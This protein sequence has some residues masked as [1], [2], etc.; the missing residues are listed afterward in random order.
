MSEFKTLFIKQIFN[1][2]EASADAQFAIL[3]REELLP[4]APSL[5]QEFFWAYEH[6]QKLVSVIWHFGDS[7]FSCKVEDEFTDELGIDSFDFDELVE[8]AKVGGWTLVKV[9]E[10]T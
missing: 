8:N 9:Y 10:P 3:Q 2:E 6:P 7:H 1:A 5:G 4:F